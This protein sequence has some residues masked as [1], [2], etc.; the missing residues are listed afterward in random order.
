MHGS[1]LFE[2]A[3]IRVVPHV[4]R[5]EF[6]NVG[7]ILICP[8]KKFLKTRFAVNQN[9]LRALCDEVDMEELDRHIQAFDRIS[10]G[11]PDS[12]PIGKLP[13]KERFRWLTASRSTILQTSPVHPG[14]CPDPQE[15]L[16]KLF[17]KLVG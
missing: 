1:H 16:D 4:E 11:G 13:L 3:I 15:M 14:L 6:I 7:V 17:R 12:G 10:N 2:Y 8:G 9:R 5:E